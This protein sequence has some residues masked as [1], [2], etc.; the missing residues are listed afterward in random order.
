MTMMERRNRKPNRKRV[1]LVRQRQKSL[2]CPG[3]DPGFTGVTGCYKK[4]GKIHK[5]NLVAPKKTRG[6]WPRV[7][8]VNQSKKI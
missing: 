7:Q 8:E 5:R 2:P 6:F 4:S 3:P 1:T